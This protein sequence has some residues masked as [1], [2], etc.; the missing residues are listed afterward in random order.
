MWSDD[1]TGDVTKLLDV[2]VR[3]DSNGFV[4]AK[5]RQGEI[6]RRT[7]GAN[8]LQNGSTSN[9]TATSYVSCML[10]ST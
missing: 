10:Y 7:P 4:D 1:Q 9:D 8:N 6:V 3:A 5:L 2:T